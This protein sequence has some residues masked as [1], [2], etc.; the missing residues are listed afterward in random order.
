MRRVNPAP[1]C[2]IGEILSTND[3]VYTHYDTRWVLVHIT[4]E[5]PVSLSMSGRLIVGTDS[6]VVDTCDNWGYCTGMDA[7]IHPSWNVGQN[8]NGG[9]VPSRTINV[10]LQNPY[11]A[12]NHTVRGPAVT[13]VPKAEIVGGSV[14]IA[15]DG[16]S[17]IANDSIMLP[18]DAPPPD[19]FESDP[20]I[21]ALG[22][23]QADSFIIVVLSLPHRGVLF[24]TAGMIPILTV[25]FP[26]D[27]TGQVTYLPPPL[28]SGTTPDF[29]VTQFLFDIKDP[30]INFRSAPAIAQINVYS[31][32]VLL[33]QP[34]VIASI[35]HKCNDIRAGP[36]F[37]IIFWDMDAAA[38]SKYYQLTIIVQSESP[39]SSMS[40]SLQN[41]DLLNRPEVYRL[42]GDG[43]IDLELKVIARYE[44]MLQILA[45][46]MILY[47]CTVNT[48][49]VI[50]TMENNFVF[51]S[52]SSN[53]PSRGPGSLSTT[54]IIP[55]AITDNPALG[56]TTGA[57]SGS[58]LL[59]LVGIFGGT[60]L[61]V[62][63]C[64]WL[65]VRA[66]RARNAARRAQGELETLKKLVESMQ[67]TAA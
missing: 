38:R 47:A 23:G 25:P 51:R 31:E 8:P 60:G 24:Q 43:D 57:S 6:F 21:A 28:Q 55:L 61:C 34:C 1:G 22:S 15:P 30:V 12:Y 29:N 4:S 39:R 13:F 3:T 62:L 56:S 42:A 58:A 14:T 7:F 64:I 53:F 59:I 67:T 35:F 52:A 45:D 11:R 66:R 36:Q 50:V 65:V 17:I 19:H 63:W 26:L 10:H 32:V 37:S 16:L 20:T 33:C 44:R 54:I 49:S 48:G 40:F 27:V 41:K 2:E 9:R 18:S 5:A 46:P